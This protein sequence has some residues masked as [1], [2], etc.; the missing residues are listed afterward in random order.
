MSADTFPISTSTVTIIGAGPVGL[1]TALALAKAG[2]DVVVF[3]SEKDVLTSPRAMIYLTV[4]LDEFMKMGLYD[5]L[6]EAGYA[7]ETGLSWRKPGG[8][9]LAKLTG[10]PGHPVIQ[11]GQHDVARIMLNHLRRH[12]NVRVEFN[13]RLV[14]F[15][16]SGETVK[17]IIES[18][19]ER[20]TRKHTSQYLVGADG[21]KSTV[22]H[23]LGIPLEGFT[24]NDFDVVAANIDYDV[25]SLG[26]EPGNF[27]VDEQY[28][29]V[30]ARLG[31][32]SSWR[33]AS[34]GLGLTTGFL[35]AA[36]LGNVLKEII[37]DGQPLARLQEYGQERRYRF[38]E[39]TNKAAITNRKR[40]LST[41]S[42]DVEEREEF[43][44]QLNERNPAI[45]KRLLDEEFGISSTVGIK[46]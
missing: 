29:A 24:W 26:W 17:A 28:W 5:D 21:G 45:F 42:E 33:V 12:E 8:Q 23:I 19:A 9:V 2:I 40:L 46:V 30:V 34:G 15:E 16:Q 31:K 32:G 43:F 36:L 37:K 39:Y 18:G 4:V 22:R 6:L 44:A 35:D 27:I 41:A 10:M 14:E 3:D 20:K 11:L 38:L 13:T 25:E 1:F 7:N